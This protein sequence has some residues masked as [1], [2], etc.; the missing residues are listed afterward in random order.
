MPSQ[1]EL[2]TRIDS[3]NAV[4]Q[5]T[6]TM[7]MI[8]VAKY[9]T[10]SKKQKEAVV[11]AS[12]LDDIK[13][14]FISNHEEHVRQKDIDTTNKDLLIVI[15]SDKGFCGNF[16]NNIFKKT[17]AFLN[18]ANINNVD[19]FP[20]GK[21]INDFLTKRGVKTHT[22]YVDILKK[23][24]INTIGEA[25]VNLTLK[26]EYNKIFIIYNHFISFSKKSV[27]SIISLDAKPI[28]L[29]VNNDI[30]KQ[31][32]FEPGYNDFFH[33]LY[34]MDVQ[35]QIIKAL[36]E[37]CVAEHSARMFNMS[38]A[39]DNAEALLKRLRILYN[40]MRQASITNEIIEISAG[41]KNT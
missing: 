35:S 16:N 5:M 37:S 39:T 24:D 22:D 33:R 11:Y 32:I 8:S 12:M 25:V 6:K 3:V 27:P 20:I 31:F 7:K 34:M 38:K 36:F 26:G 30:E 40:Q 28:S 15:S 10:V 21:K 14:K 2:R 13:S 18:E 29:P 9:N 23:V 19:I 41:Y 4:K 17:L 1:K